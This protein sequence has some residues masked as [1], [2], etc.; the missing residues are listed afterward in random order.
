MV[1][2]VHHVGVGSLPCTDD[3]RVVRGLPVHADVFD[4]AMLEP[5][6]SVTHESGVL[7]WRKSTVTGTWSLCF[8]HVSYVPTSTLSTLESH[9][10]GTKT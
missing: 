6:R 5:E 1:A 3:P 2:E 4:G 10:R 8:D 9:A 7:Q